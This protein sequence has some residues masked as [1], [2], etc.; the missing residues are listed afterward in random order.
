MHYNTNTSSSSKLTDLLLWRH[1]CTSSVL[2]T[3]M[4]VVHRVNLNN[5]CWKQ[6]R[7]LK[8]LAMQKLWRM[9]T[10][11]D[12]CVF[13]NFICVHTV[14]CCTCYSSIY[15]H[16][17]GIEWLFLLPTCLSYYSRWT[18]SETHLLQN[19]FVLLCPLRHCAL[20]IPLG[21]TFL[22]ISHYTVVFVVMLPHAVSVNMAAWYAAVLTMCH[23]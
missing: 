10:H 3:D 13:C 17:G 15:M 12:L 9:T 18:R 7:S 4:F 14:E 5:S 16:S 2:N 22:N 23:V 20:L 19:L 6:I 8:H 21:H 1:D 11:Q